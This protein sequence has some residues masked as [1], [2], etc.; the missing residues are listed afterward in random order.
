MRAAENLATRL[1]DGQVWLSDE[2]K[3]ETLMD[4][5]SE[6]MDAVIDKLLARTLEQA[7]RYAV[8]QMR[9]EMVARIKAVQPTKKASGK[10]NKGK[11]SA[12]DYRHLHGIVAMM[13]TDQEAKEKRM[14][15][16]EGVLSSNQS[17][18]EERVR[19]S[20]N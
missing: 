2:L 10:F 11:L 1:E 15:E 4:D 13:N 9:A 8:D 6:R 19:P 17:T 14:L 3:K 12:E 16:L 5:T 20:W 18:E 7:D